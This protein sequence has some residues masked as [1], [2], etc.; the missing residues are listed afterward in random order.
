MRLLRLLGRFSGA[1]LRLPREPSCALLRFSRK[2]RNALMRLPRKDRTS[3]T[4][5]PR[6]EKIALLPRKERVALLRWPRK[7]RNALLLLSRKPQIALLRSPRR[8]RHVEQRFHRY[9]SA[10]R[11]AAAADFSRRKRKLNQI[12]ALRSH[13]QATGGT[14]AQ[15]RRL[16][17]LSLPDEIRSDREEVFEAQRDHAVVHAVGHKHVL[18][19]RSR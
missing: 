15:T 12:P 18:G 1:R 9:P 8:H 2:P 17:D 10:A 19:L 14:P 6:K 13:K 7:D 4:R 16:R 5:L 11:A 3:T